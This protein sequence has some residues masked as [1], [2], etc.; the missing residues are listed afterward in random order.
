MFL[1]W[2]C[3]NWRETMP[4]WLSLW[5]LTLPEIGFCYNVLVVVVTVVA[6]VVLLLL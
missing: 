2:D 3:F 1:C 6:M 5:N 4:F